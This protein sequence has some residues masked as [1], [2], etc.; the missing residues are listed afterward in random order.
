M[1]S[2]QAAHAT[3]GATLSG[4]VAILLW[5]SLAL[6]T[7]LTGNLPP[8]LVLACCF[9]FAGAFGLAWAARAGNA[10]LRAMRAPAAALGLSTC[11]L[12]GYHALYFFSLK[13][14]PPVEANLV[15]YLW[16][17]LIVLFSGL[18]PGVRLR[19]GNV[20][21]ALLGLTAAAL[22]V[23]GGRG[24]SVDPAYASGYLA[25]FAAAVV[26][27]GYSVLN[28]RFAGVDSAAIVPACIGVS[29]LGMAAHAWFEPTTAISASQWLVLAAMGIGP[30]GVAFTLWDRG[31]KHG[32]IALLGSL[33]YLAPLLSTLWLVVAGRAEPRWIQ[34]LAVALLLFGAW[35]SV[36]AS[37]VATPAAAAP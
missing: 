20:V 2:A 12:F 6:L 15:N 9:G 1:N 7:T 23:T 26:W 30:T 4:L 5:S 32:D 29:L 35:L 33:S 27:G 22:L 34:A 11:A 13:R 8:F 10:G 21:G 18:L 19:A 37:R 16:P 28:R 36:R 31:T 14:A 3:T 17:L 24:L 25:A